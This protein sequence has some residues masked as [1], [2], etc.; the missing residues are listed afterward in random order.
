MVDQ[1]RSDITVNGGGT[2]PAG[3]YETVTVNGGGTVQGEL[4]CTTLRINGAA[5]CTGDVKA[6]TVYIN[7]S[8]TFNGHLQ[9]LDLTV[10]G[11][12][13]VRGGVGAGTIN[14]RGNVNVDAG[15]N[16]NVLDLRGFVRTRGD[17]A[18]DEIKGDGA[19]EAVNVRCTSLDLGVYGPSDVKSVDGERVILRPP[20]SFA[21]VFMF[22]ARK[23]F[24]AETITASEVW[25][26][27][28]AANVVNAGNATLGDGCR[29][30]LVHYS[31]ALL[32]Q[33]GAVVTEERR[34]E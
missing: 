31:G 20:G 9:A 23:E 11:D 33:P 10:N 25:L 32:K 17:L 5:T 6:A 8:G 14:V 7:G 29:I 27:N 26:S 16:A 13:G 34:A 18:I 19:L 21:D 24:R 1:G 4:V 12:C 22:F 3:T 2:I 28:T 15:V 30:G